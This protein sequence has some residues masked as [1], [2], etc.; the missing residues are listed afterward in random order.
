MVVARSAAEI[1]VV[2]PRRAS[3]ETVKAVPKRAVLSAAIGGSPSARTFSSSSVRQ[4]SPRPCLAMKLTAAG[5]TASAAIVRSPS[6]SRSSSSTRI[7]ILP[8]RISSISSAVA[9]QRSLLPR[10]RDSH[11][12]P[13]CSS[14]VARD[15]ALPAPVGS[16]SMNRF[17]SFAR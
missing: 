17:T 7:T 5:V 9:G 13:P 12:P 3:I 10:A 14:A 15:G 11:H 6:F 1:P 2:T 8:L 4:I 16:R